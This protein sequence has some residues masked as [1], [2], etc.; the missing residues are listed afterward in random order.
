[1]KRWKI[2]A[3]REHNLTV[4]LTAEALYTWISDGSIPESLN[5]PEYKTEIHNF[6]LEKDDDVYAEWLGS[7]YVYDDKHDQTYVLRLIKFTS[8]R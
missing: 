1:M 4:F 5:D 7:E 3:K 8:A 6:H 2:T